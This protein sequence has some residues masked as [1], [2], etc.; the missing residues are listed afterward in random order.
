[1]ASLDSK[2]TPARTPLPIVDSAPTAG[3][4]AEAECHLAEPGAAADVAAGKGCAEHVDPLAWRAAG[5]RYYAYNFFLRQK[6]GGPVRHVSISAGFTCPNVDGTVAKG[7][8]V[9]CDNRS[10]SPSRRQPWHPVTG[11]IDEGIRRIRMRYKADR[12]LAYF[13]PGSNTYGPLPKLERVF[14]EALAHP[15]VCGLVV[16]TRPDCVP[17]EVLELLQDL[18]RI[19]YV[20]VEYGVQTIHDRSL[21][22][23][24]RGHHYDAF[25]DAVDRSVGR[26][27]EIGTHLIF[28]L[29][30][31]SREDML[32]TADEIA[33]RPLHSIKLHQLYAVHHTPLAD[34]VASGSVKLMER[35][36]YA[37]I[38]VDVLER[39]PP[40]F[41]IERTSGDAPPAFLVGPQ[42]CLDKPALKQA[43]DGELARRDTWQGKLWKPS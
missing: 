13:Q 11:Q 19:H 39:L 35:D 38:V 41:V 17:G 8:C 31:E 26:G 32:A 22:W 23:M 7:G 1:M 30:G 40:H 3:A 42:W 14:R 20:S 6:F 5:L 24:N 36:E 25:V 10:F 33:R 37:S 18:A 29:P 12:F 28:G 21:D 9:F 2:R 15:A 16:G 4:E 43:I 27:F 34:W